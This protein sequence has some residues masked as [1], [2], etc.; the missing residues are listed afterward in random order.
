MSRTA[1]PW[2]DFLEAA[3]GLSGTN[4]QKCGIALLLEKVDDE[5]RKMIEVAMGRPELTSSAIMAALKQRMSVKASEYTLRRHR[6]GLCSCQ[7]NG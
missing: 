2:D 7:K 3:E 1:G 6:R 5:A 4:Y